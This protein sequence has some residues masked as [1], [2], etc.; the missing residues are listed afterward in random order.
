MAHILLT[1]DDD[2]VRAF[3]KR[4]LELDG[5]KVTAVEDG[6]E[7]ALV[8][9]QQQGRF[10]LLLSDIRMPEMDGIELAMQSSARY[11]GLPILLMTGYADQRERSEEVGKCVK[12]VLTK[13]FSLVE[14]RKAVTTALAEEEGSQQTAFA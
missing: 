9:L 4:A 12:D 11:P 5:H 13:P 2:A 1:E 8:L 7:A 10:D 14:V 6:A 3:V